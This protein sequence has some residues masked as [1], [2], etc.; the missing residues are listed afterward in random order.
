MKNYSE[1]EIKENKNK[2]IHRSHMKKEHRKQQVQTG[3]T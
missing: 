3:L 2:L 1:K